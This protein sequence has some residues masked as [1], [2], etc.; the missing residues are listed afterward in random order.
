MSLLPVHTESVSLQREANVTKDLAAHHWPTKQSHCSNRILGF[1]FGACSPVVTVLQIHEEG[2]TWVL[3]AAVLSI[4][5][6]P[7]CSVRFFLL[8]ERYRKF[9]YRTLRFPT[10]GLRER[11]RC[12]LLLHFSVAETLTTSAGFMAPNW[13]CHPVNLPVHTNIWTILIV[14]EAD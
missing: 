1:K 13:L 8:R 2:I 11:F 4:F 14:S 9:F 5:F 10:S 7:Q 3:Y 6:P 12:V